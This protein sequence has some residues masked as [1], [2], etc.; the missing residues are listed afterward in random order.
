MCTDICKA[1]LNITPGQVRPGWDWIGIRAIVR[2]WSAGRGVCAQALLEVGSDWLRFFEDSILR[3]LKWALS[4]GA[5]DSVI[6]TDLE[7]H[8]HA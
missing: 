1:K 2:V 3:H 5:P 6:V 4:K 7:S 8:C